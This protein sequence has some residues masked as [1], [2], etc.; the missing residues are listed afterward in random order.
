L[1]WYL[2]AFKKYATF[3]GRARRKEFWM[4]Y[5]FNTIFSFGALSLDSILGFTFAG[6]R[7]NFIQILY[8]VAVIFPGMALTVRRLHDVGK[9]GWYLFY[10]SVAAG[11][12]LFIGIRLHAFLSNTNY[13]H[14]GKAVLWGPIIIIGIY[15]LKL[16]CSD[17]TS[18]EN[19]YGPN[20][21]ENV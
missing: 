10:I 9:S 2:M 4:F 5:L 8:G 20:P 17:G 11:F 15:Y 19:Q 12:V 1:N 18:G 14:W 3:K 6:G 16:L 13:L 7:S 21:K